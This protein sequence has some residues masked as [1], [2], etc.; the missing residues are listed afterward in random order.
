MVHLME[1]KIYKITALCSKDCFETQQNSFQ[2]EMNT[3]FDRQPSFVKKAVHLLV[4]ELD[5]R[6]DWVGS[7]KITEDIYFSVP[8][9]RPKEN[10]FIQQKI[11]H[12]DCLEKS[13]EKQ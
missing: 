1:E 12:Y 8:P 10:E 13:N 9:M 7:K 3:A 11:K 4:P 6:G 2:E 5:N